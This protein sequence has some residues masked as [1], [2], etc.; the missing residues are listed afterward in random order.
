MPLAS[1]RPSAVADAFREG[2]RAVR[3]LPAALDRRRDRY[4]LFNAVQY[5][6]SL[7]IQENIPEAA[8]NRRAERTRETVR[9]RI[10]VLSAEG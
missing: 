6:E 1:G 4:G 7:F 8:A 3:P 10:A 9:E 2:Y 5:L